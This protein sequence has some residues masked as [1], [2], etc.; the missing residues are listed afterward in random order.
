METTNQN[1]IVNSGMNFRLKEYIAISIQRLFRGFVERRK[2]R[3]ML[4]L[5]FNKAAFTIQHAIKAWRLKNVIRSVA[6]RRAFIRSHISKKK[7]TFKDSVYSRV[8]VADKAVRNLATYEEIM[9]L[10][11]TIIEIRRAHNTWST[12]VLLK[13]LVEAKS[14]LQRAI[15]LVRILYF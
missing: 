4:W 3:E 7:S 12:D 11:R 6:C 15:V 14:D 1:R 13:A 2:L 8:D 5:R 9:G 10:W